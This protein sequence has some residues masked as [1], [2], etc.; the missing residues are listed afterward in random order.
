[1]RLSRSLSFRPAS[2]LCACL[3]LVHPTPGYSNSEEV[4]VGGRLRDAELVGLNGPAR[5]LNEFRGR[6]LIIN[7]WASW[8]GPCRQEMA[9]LERLAWR[10]GTQYFGIIG[11]STDDYADK[12][13]TLLRNSHA[14]ISQFIDHE[15]RMENMLGASRL[16]L[17][18][19][20]AADGRIL[21]KIYG[22]RDWDTAEMRALIDATFRSATRKNTSLGVA[23]SPSAFS[24]S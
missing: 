18:V 15:L 17:T 23:V 2:V 12:A 4:P 20:V 3:L 8:C 5:H 11:V 21:L 9:S 7:V 14:T 10:N 19:L 24:G 6:P 1:M 13:M 22:A 16:P